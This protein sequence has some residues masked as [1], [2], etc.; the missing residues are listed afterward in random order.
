MR[1][2]DYLQVVGYIDQ[3]AIDIA[4]NDTGGEMDPHGADAVSP[5]D[6]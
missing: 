5:N 4:A 1:T 3:T 6:I 2:P